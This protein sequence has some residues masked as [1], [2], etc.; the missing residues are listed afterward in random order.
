MTLL[1]RILTHP[2]NQ[3]VVSRLG[4]APTR[5]GGW[6]L[7]TDFAVAASASRPQQFDCTRFSCIQLN[8]GAF[9]GS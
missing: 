4:L 1:E 3:Q 9:M 5:A 8:E 6:A 7:V 2:D